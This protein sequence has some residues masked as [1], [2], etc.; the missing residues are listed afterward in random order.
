[1]FIQLT[2]VMHVNSK[3]EIICHTINSNVKRQIIKKHY[4]NQFVHCEHIHWFVLDMH[5]IDVTYFVILTNCHSWCGYL[6][7]KTMEYKPF[8]QYVK[9]IHKPVKDE[10]YKFNA[11]REC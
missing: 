9:L 4:T 2:K 1:M 10:T 7:H 6:H 3:D 5:E 8:D 11:R